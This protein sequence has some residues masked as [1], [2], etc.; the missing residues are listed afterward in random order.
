[1]VF[2]G[3]ATFVSF[4]V[5]LRQPCLHVI[6]KPEAFKFYL[7][8]LPRIEF[9]PVDLITD[10]GEKAGRPLIRVEGM[11]VLAG[12]KLDPALA[13]PGNVYEEALGCGEAFG[14][15]QRLA[16]EFAF[17]KRALLQRPHMS[18]HA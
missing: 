4:C 9:P 14:T 5:S 13:R 11:A 10:G 16:L 3:Q 17:A 7:Y 8:V 18:L 2:S 15:M 1:M 12:V 6:I